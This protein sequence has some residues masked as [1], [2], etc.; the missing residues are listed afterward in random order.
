MRIPGVMG[1]QDLAPMAHDYHELEI[2]QENT[3]SVDRGRI[4]SRRGQMET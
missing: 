1:K 2:R 3:V 4:S